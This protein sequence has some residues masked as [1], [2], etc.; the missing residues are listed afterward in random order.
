MTKYFFRWDWIFHFSTLCPS[1]FGNHGK[2][3]SRFLKEKS[4]EISYYHA[5]NESTNYYSR[6]RNLLFSTPTG[7][8]LSTF[9]LRA[10]CENSR[11]YPPHS[12]A[13]VLKFSVK[14]FQKIFLQSKI[15]QNCL[16][17]LQFW[18][19]CGN[20]RSHLLNKSW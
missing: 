14:T 18:D 13:K 15:G 9:M 19:F 3:L 8:L 2:F 12:F 4:R 17:R 7:C 5:V 16:I 6:E 10:Q 1:Q 20:L 11:N